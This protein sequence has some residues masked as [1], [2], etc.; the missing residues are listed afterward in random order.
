MRNGLAALGLLVAALP[1]APRA[2]PLAIDDA[3]R[4][5]WAHNPGLAASASMVEAARADADR[6][7]LAGLPTLSLTAKGV[8]TDEPMMAFGLKLDQG[9]IGQADFNPASLDAP[10]P[11]TGFGAGASVS[12]PLYMGG[13]LSA[14]QRAAGKVADAEAADDAR[15]R[16][17]LAEAALSTVDSQ[18]R[19]RAEMIELAGF[20]VDRDS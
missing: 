6:A 20:I 19:A 7:R 4:A 12:M 13:R 5:A 11:R 2:A 17:A 15:R 1:A 8:R 18:P 16:M 14:G 10:D 3:I 9:R